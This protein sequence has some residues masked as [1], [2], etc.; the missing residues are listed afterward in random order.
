M[1][2]DEVEKELLLVSS[3][4]AAG[5]SSSSKSVKD[6][7][8]LFQLFHFCPFATAAAA[9]EPLPNHNRRCCRRC[10]HRRHFGL[11]QPRIGT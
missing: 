11:E 8:S 10:H 9:L 4:A 2:A 6:A 3:A 5:M 7:P 1:K